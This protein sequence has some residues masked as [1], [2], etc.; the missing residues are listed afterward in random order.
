[1]NGI[2]GLMVQGWYQIGIVFFLGTTPVHAECKGAMHVTPSQQCWIKH[3]QQVSE[4][5]HSVGR[6]GTDFLHAWLS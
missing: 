2:F 4:C 5:N 3:A 6:H 1:M